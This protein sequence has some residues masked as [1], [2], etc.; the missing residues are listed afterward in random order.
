MDQY[1]TA[2]SSDPIDRRVEEHTTREVRVAP[3]REGRFSLEISFV[4]R[5]VGTVKGLSERLIGRYEMT[6]IDWFDRS[7]VALAPVQSFLDSFCFQA[8]TL[9][10]LAIVPGR[11]C[12]RVAIN[13]WQA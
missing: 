12:S 4:S 8:Q 1:S 7:I 2:R 9:S 3:L 5:V 11:R 13:C 10:L 6:R